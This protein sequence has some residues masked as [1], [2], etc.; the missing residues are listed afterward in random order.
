MTGLS[1]RTRGRKTEPEYCTW[2]TC[3]TIER[4]PVELYWPLPRRHVVDDADAEA[5]VPSHAPRYPDLWRGK[6]AGR[7]A[8]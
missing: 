3:G 1:G 8:W 7:R 2:S 4:V 5:A 6:L